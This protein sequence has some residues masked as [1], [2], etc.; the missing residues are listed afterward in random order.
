MA[1][2]F[3][4]VAQTKSVTKTQTN[5]SRKHVLLMPLCLMP[6]CVEAIVVETTDFV[7]LNPTGQ[8]TTNAL[9]MT[10]AVQ[11]LVM[12]V[13]RKLGNALIVSNIVHLLNALRMTVTNAVLI[14]CVMRL[15]G[16]VLKKNIATMSS[17][18]KIN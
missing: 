17:N 10:I 1:A 3:N 4:L 7:D 18:V 15:L 16:N 12:F 6:L 9:R 11:N 2:V 14:M 8:Q 13:I 5:A